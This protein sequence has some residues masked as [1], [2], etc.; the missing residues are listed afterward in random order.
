MLTMRVRNKK[1]ALPL[2]SKLLVAACLSILLA[3]QATPVNSAQEK[4][5]RPQPEQTQPEQPQREQ[6]EQ[7][8]SGQGQDEP[9][10]LH[11]DLVV[12]SVTVTDAAGLYAHGLSAKDFSLSEDGSPQQ[13]SSFG[14][15]ESPFAAAILIDMSGSMGYKFGL[16]RAAAASFV[17]HIRDNDQVAVYG[18]NNKVRQ[19]QDFSNVRD[20]TDYIWDAKAEDMTRL[21]D[22]MDEAV[23]ALAKR[24]EKRRAILL[25]SDGCD[26]TSSKSSLESVTKKALGAGVTVYSVDLIDDNEISRSTSETMQ[27]RRG[28]A[29]MKGLATQSGGR[30]VRSPQGDKL[31]EAFTNIVEELRNQYTLTYYTTNQKRD[32]RWRKID[33]SV[34]R[35]GLTARARRGYFA[36]KS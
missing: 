31:E 1:R 23:A 5:A 2:D 28:R 3:A 10:R 30:Y 8:A 25:I 35:A 19:F 32:G 26:T 20:I 29:E 13:V 18:F 27:L 15:E 21:Y 9:V 33:V 4:K 34:T 17:D 36:P 22:C 14:A 16:V 12:V 7:P 11:S 6:P 24:E